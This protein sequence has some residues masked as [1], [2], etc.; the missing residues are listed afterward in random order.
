MLQSLNIAGDPALADVLSVLRSISS[1]LESLILLKRQEL[2]FI[3]G[4]PLSSTST[5]S[6]TSAPTSASIPPDDAAEVLYTNDDADYYRELRAKVMGR[7]DELK[8]DPLG[9]HQG[10]DRDQ[11][12]EDLALQPDSSPLL[13]PRSDV[14]S[15]DSDVY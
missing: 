12:G 3:T 10:I 13:F 2:A 11:D 7:L 1:H 6:A 8:D 14:V 15:V 9:F 4:N 5:T